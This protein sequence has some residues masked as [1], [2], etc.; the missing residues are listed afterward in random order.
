MIRI[1]LQNIPQ[2][3]RDIA[4][5]IASTKPRRGP[6]TDPPAPILIANSYNS[7]VLF[8]SRESLSTYRTWKVLFK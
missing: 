3:L 5:I 7:K 6:R 1:S 4:V 8:E 2:L